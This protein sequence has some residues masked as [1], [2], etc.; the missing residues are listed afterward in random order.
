MEGDG[1]VPCIAGTN[2]NAGQEQDS[3][4]LVQE[5]AHLSASK[6]LRIERNE[7]ALRIRPAIAVHISSQGVFE[8]SEEYRSSYRRS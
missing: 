3:Q 1:E 2:A 7:M 5:R 8:T 6:R 4:H